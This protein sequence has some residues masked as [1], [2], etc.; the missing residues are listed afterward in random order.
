MAG[1]GVEVMVR[2]CESSGLMDVMRGLG[3]GFRGLE[4]WRASGA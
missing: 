4:L 3:Y 1:L 2:D